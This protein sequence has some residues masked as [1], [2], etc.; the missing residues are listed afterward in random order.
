[1]ILYFSATGNSKYAAEKIAEATGDRAVSLQKTDSKI[2]LK[3][4]ENLGIITPVYFQGLPSV[5]EELL[6]KLTIHGDASNYIFT[7]FTYGTFSG[8]GTETINGYLKRFGLQ[9][10]ADYSVKT[11]DTWTTTFDLSNKEKVAGVVR[12]EEPQLAEI[13]RKVQKKEKGHFQK[14]KPIRLVANALRGT[15]DD[16][17]KT[18]HLHVSD[19]CIGCGLCER[20]CPVK[21]IQMKDGKPAWVK[22]QCAMCLQ[23]LHK[24]P[25]FAIQYDNKTQKHGQYTHEKYEGKNWL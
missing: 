25:K 13:I 10:S 24:C 19:G 21:A 6:E 3:S 1:M 5:T 22:D 20:N 7:V 4:G 23:C 12:R 16:A 8:R 2:D 9:I 14:N 18:E 17:R 11:A 15:Y